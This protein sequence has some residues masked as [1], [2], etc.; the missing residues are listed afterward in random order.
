MNICCDSFHKINLFFF[1][2]FVSCF[3]IFFY[4]KKEA[5]ISGCYV[6]PKKSSYFNTTSILS[7]IG[8]SKNISALSRKDLSRSSS[9]LSVRGTVYFLFC[10][11]LFLNPKYHK[12]SRA[13]TT[14]KNN[15]KGKLFILISSYIIR[16]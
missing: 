3:V 16:L 10:R 4:K 5:K 1:L 14:E 8:V 15:T 9:K 11:V 2:A 7:F 13:L 12:R 6:F